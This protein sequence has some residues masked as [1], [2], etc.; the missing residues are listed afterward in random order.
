MPAAVV[1]AAVSW[2]LDLYIAVGILQV[3]ENSIPRTSPQVDKITIVL[4]CADA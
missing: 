1:E 4:G 2:V 3:S